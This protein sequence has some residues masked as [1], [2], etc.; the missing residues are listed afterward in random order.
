M[1]VAAFAW[2]AHQ[3]WRLV[4]IGN[5]DEFHARPAAALA[6]WED[7]S[8]IV[9]GRDLQ[10][11][12]TWLG[13]GGSGRFALVTNLRGYGER[14]PDRESRGRLVTDL[15]TG[16]GTYAD[17]ASA[18]LGD[19]NPFNLILADA[20][21]ATFLSNRPDEIRTALAHGI[22]G[23]SNGALDEPWP[24]TLQLKAALLDWLNADAIGFAPLFEALASKSI[25]DIGLHP[26]EPSDVPQEASE[27]PVFIRNAVYGTRCSTVVA[28]DHE[29]VGTIV[30][31]RFSPEGEQTGETAID[32]AWP[33]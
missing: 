2:H 24:K 29:G 27:T 25:A 5:R 23:L 8:S 21:R 22:Y 15:L 26:S 3:R 28:V 11:G 6:P 13:V 20:E 1:C 14:S 18:A 4:A 19:F 33:A 30:E 16:E 10:S 32:F 12:G 17:P 31:R 7:D 9:A